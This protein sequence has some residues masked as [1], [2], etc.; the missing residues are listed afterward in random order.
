MKKTRRPEATPL[1]SAANRN[2]SRRDVVAINRKAVNAI[3][4]CGGSSLLFSYG[5][6]NI[7]AGA[8]SRHTIAKPPVVGSP[9]ESPNALQR[10]KGQ[11]SGSIALGSSGRTTSC[12][13]QKS[14]IDD[15]AVA[16]AMVVRYARMAM[17]K[18]SPLPS[19]VLELLAQR[20]AEDDPACKVVANWLERCRLI[21]T[22]TLPLANRK[23]GHR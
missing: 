9:R 17:V 15:P 4:K 10:Q 18:R 11:K 7:E 14:V 6:P 16:V 1:F 5:P 2:A 22:N 19:A 23:A 12:D 8:A 21:R 13:D 20:L 3:K